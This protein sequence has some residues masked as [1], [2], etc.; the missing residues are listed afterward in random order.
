MELHA[1]GVRLGASY[2]APLIGLDAGRARAL[3]ALK[4]IGQTAG[5]GADG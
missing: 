4:T 5:V 3:A 1:A 2:P